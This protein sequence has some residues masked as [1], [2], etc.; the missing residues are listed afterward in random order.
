MSSLLENLVSK[1]NQCIF[2]KTLCGTKLLLCTTTSLL[3]P[4]TGSDFTEVK[5]LLITLWNKTADGNDIFLGLVTLDTNGLPVD[6]KPYWYLLQGRRGKDDIV[7]GDI[8]IAFAEPEVLKTNKGAG[9]DA[10]KVA[11]EKVSLCTA[12]THA[13]CLRR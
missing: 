4:L 8:M 12:H 1:L 7:S 3:T 11:R 10:E 13:R 5:K 9:K 6:G 2:R